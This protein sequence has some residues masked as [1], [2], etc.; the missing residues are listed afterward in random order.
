MNNWQPLTQ[1]IVLLQ[2]PLRGF[3]MDFGR[4]VTL[5][6]LRDQRV[7]IH[8]SAPFTAQDVKK[9]REFGEP[10]WL[11]DATLMHDSFARQGRAAFPD[12]PYLA[13]EGFSRRAGVETQPLFPAP[14]DWSGE[15]AVLPIGGLR[16]TNEHAF[17]HRS[18]R[19]LVVADLLFHFPPATKGWARFFAAQV[20]RLPR[21]LGLSFFFRMMIR[22]RAAFTSSMKTILKWDFTQIVLAHRTPILTNAKAEFVRALRADEFDVGG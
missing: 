20:M 21:L 3:G 18:S 4:T 17:Y 2:Y 9:I 13:P 1:D 14:R 11:V 7:I 19:T 5:L 12:L 22:D 16:L 10:A 6:R 15:V 8:S